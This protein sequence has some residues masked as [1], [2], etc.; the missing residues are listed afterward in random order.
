MTAL[1]F[2]SGL[3]NSKTC[4]VEPRAT[5]LTLWPSPCSFFPG[6]MTSI[7]R[8]LPGDPVS[9]SI[10]SSRA[11]GDG[12]GQG[13]RA[14]VCIHRPGRGFE[15]PVPSLGSGP[16]CLGWPQASRSFVSLLT[17]VERVGLGPHPAVGAAQWGS[18]HFVMAQ[19]QPQ[20]LRNEKLHR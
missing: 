12:A 1:K 16:H 8:K 17:T 11:A 2:S 10:Q 3:P 6:K 18:Q 20:K 19:T 9:H 13:A 7:I 4:A 5:V 15:A 14:C